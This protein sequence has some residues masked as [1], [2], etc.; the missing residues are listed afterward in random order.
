M[1]WWPHQLGKERESPNQDTGMFEESWQQLP[2][3]TNDH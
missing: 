1:G 2:P 3:T